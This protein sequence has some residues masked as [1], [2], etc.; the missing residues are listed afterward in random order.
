MHR[1]S[2]IAFV[3]E[4]GGAVVEQ[5]AERRPEWS[6][7]YRFYYK[8]IVPVHGLKHGLFVEMRLTSDEDPDFPEVTLVGAH[9]QKR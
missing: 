8:V 6:A 7:A 1:K 5:I 9:P 3:R 2:V 4:N